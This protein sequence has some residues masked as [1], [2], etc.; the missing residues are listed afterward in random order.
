[1]QE[2]ALRTRLL[3]RSEWPDE[4][5]DRSREQV[6][7]F[8]GDEVAAAAE[9]LKAADVRKEAF[10]PGARMPLDWLCGSGDTDW[11]SRLHRLL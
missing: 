7:F 3:A 9:V 1:M 4:V 5:A 10:D 11:D 6:G 8:C 2:C